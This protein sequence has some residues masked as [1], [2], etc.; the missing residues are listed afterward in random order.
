MNECRRIAERLAEYVDDALAPAER[1]DVERHLE[2]CPPCRVGASREQGAHTVLRACA[3]QLR[4]QPLPPG[5]R[6]RCEAL[7]QDHTR[8]SSWAA[9]RARLIPVTIT[10]TLIVLTGAA[11]LV[12]A[13]ERSDAF[14]AAQLTA[15]HTRCFREFVSA[16]APGLN[17][18]ELEARLAAEYGWDVHVPPSDDPEGI[19]LVHA[20]RC[21]YAEGR[22]PHVLYR[23]NGE[24]VSL[25]M[26]EGVTRKAADVT[27]FGHR[28]RIWTRGATTF[29]LVTPAAA[30]D[31]AAAARYVMQQAH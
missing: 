7:L 29:V 5:L 26:L 15:D 22:I 4:A 18:A 20:R 25:Y 21:L 8:V 1:S 11:I 23:V 2:A 13:T 28:S 9:W 27:T 30:G 19:R 10:A 31:L 12:L 16:D 17:A 24:D 14:F 6:S 3:D